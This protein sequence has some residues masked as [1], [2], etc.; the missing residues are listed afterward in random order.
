LNTGDDM[1]DDLPQRP[2]RSALPPTRGPA[3]PS[4]PAGN[5]PLAELARLIGQ[6]DPFAEFGRQTQTHADASAP[7][8][9]EAALDWPPQTQRRDVAGQAPA[10]PPLADPQQFGA[11]AF[12]RPPFGGDR[13]QAEAEAPPYG[14]PGYPPQPAGGGFGQDPYQQHA[15]PNAYPDQDPN[16]AASYAPYGAEDDDYYDDAPPNRRRIGIIAIAGVFA[17]AVIGTAGAFGYRAIFGSSSSS[18]PPPVIKA[19]TAPS[20]IVPATASKDVQDSK[21]IT[22][23][24]NERGQGERLVSREEQPV[25]ITTA[26]P[27]NTA[28]PQNQGQNPANGAQLGSGIVGGDAKRI[29]TIAIHPDQANGPSPAPPAADAAPP[30]QAAPP[31]VVS[32]T[33]A[34]PAAPPRTINEAAA[35][36]TPRPTAPRA[37]TPAPSN[38]PLSLNPN[39]TAPA[40]AARRAAAASA[41]T[42]L[43]ATTAGGGYAV[44][45]TAQRSEA[46]AQAAFRSLQAKYPSQLG[47][48]QPLIKRVDLGAKGIYYRAMIGPYGSSG[49]AS[50]ACSSLKAA[51]GQC[52]V[53]RN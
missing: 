43:A 8:Q 19:D 32:T 18:T 27:A 13:Y 9:S 44:Q 26:R 48:Q 47:G 5:D 25:P 52:I 29:R 42:R 39:A 49:E 50:S 2:Y 11:A 51:G 36:P 35:E 20:K 34:R 21:M 10:A 33:P 46:D 17:L 16:Q 28:F 38:A 31:R 3:A 24:V 6:N 1:A 23:R 7:R 41:P 22:D 30:P 14:V 53:Q 12:D 45:V 4:A 40:P 37:A 15:D